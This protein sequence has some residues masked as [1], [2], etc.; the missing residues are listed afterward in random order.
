MESMNHDAGLRKPSNRC[1][2]PGHEQKSHYLP[3]TPDR[4]ES[5]KSL[6]EAYLILRGGG[7]GEAQS[8][9]EKL[10]DD[11]CGFFSQDPKD[12][13]YAFLSL[14]TDIR[15][16]SGYRTIRRIILS[17]RSTRGQ[18]THNPPDGELRC[19]MPV[20]TGISRPCRPRIQVDPMVWN[21]NHRLR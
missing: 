12:G 11:F 2:A 4:I 8:A 17:H 13:I 15:I 20:G 16:P 6:M 14:A 19:N 21:G 1:D 10:V 7:G 3:D 9:L 5:L 18:Q